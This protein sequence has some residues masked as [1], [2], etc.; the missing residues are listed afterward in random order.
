MAGNI[1]CP[2]GIGILRY[3]CASKSEDLE[4][5]TGN[6][7][8]EP[9]DLLYNRTDVYR[10]NVF[11]RSVDSFGVRVYLAYCK[12]LI[13]R[14]DEEVTTIIVVPF[15]CVASFNKPPAMQVRSQLLQLTVKNL[16]WYNYVGL[17][18]T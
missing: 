14:K 6:F 4:A 12:N 1:I 5:G 8:S 13:N 3:L 2:F 18:T 10:I 9:C 17:P 15:C 7:S 11:I 16:Q